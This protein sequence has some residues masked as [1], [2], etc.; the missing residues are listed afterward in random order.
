[1]SPTSGSPASEGII[2]LLPL[3]GNRVSLVWSA[4]ETLADTIMERVAGRTGDA[5]GRVRGYAA[6]HPAPL[7]PEAVKAMPLALVRPHALTAARGPGRRRRPR[8]HPLAGHGMNLGFADVVDLLR[9][10]PS[11]RSTAHRRRAGAGALCRARKEDVLSCNW[12]PTASSACSAPNLEPLRVVR[13]LGL[14]LLDKLPMVKR[15]LM[16][17]RWASEPISIQNLGISH[18]ENEARRP[19]GDGLMASCVGAQNSVEATIKKS[20]RAWAAP[21]SN[22]SRKPRTAACTNCASPATS[23]TPTR[24]ASTCSSATSTMP[25]PRAT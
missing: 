18:V 5:P 6:R 24:R 25:R 14:N 13:N 22:R 4:P 7:Q 16:P 3:P 15:R 19:A 8:V 23:C 9:V 1:M 2:A 10:W 20:S 12:P 17:T 11:A 21:R